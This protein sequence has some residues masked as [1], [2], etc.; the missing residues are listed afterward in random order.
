ME[1]YLR[2]LNPLLR[3]IPPWG[4]ALLVFVAILCILYGILTIASA[5]RKKLTPEELKKREIEF[6]EAETVVK[7][8]TKDKRNAFDRWFAQMLDEGNT[9]IVPAVAMLLVMGTM[10]LTGGLVLILSDNVPLSIGTGLIFMIFPMAYWLL[11]RSWRVGQMRKHLPE[12]L[13]AIGDAIRGGLSLEE[14]LQMTATQID[15]PLKTELQYANRQLEMGQ[16]PTF[17]MDHMARRIPIPEFRLFSTAVLVHRTTGGNLAQ[18]AERLARSSRDRQE[19]RG[20]L[21]AISA[22]SR[23][24]IF[25]LVV[26]TAVSVAILCGLDYTYLYRFIMNPYGPTLLGITLILFLIGGFWTWCIMRVNY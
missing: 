5:F 12:T 19:F 8:T 18:L 23:M 7:L 14:A 1:L 11:R 16:S 21:N 6:D 15:D 4:I 22:G 26:V 24:S 3:S 9:K 10:I 25:G 13:E 20:H 17:V 2:A